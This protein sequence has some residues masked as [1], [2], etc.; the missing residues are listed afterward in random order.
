MSSYSSAQTQMADPSGFTVWH[1][2]TLIAPRRSI[3]GRIVW[4][5]VWRRWD[6]QMWLYKTD[7]DW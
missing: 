1:R 2:W 3:A 4:G 7:L 5:K 6:G